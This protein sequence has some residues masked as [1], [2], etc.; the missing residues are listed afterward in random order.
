MRV[1]CLL[2]MG[3][4][5]AAAAASDVSAY[6]MSCHGVSRANPTLRSKSRTRICLALR[7]CWAKVAGRRRCLVGRDAH[8]PPPTSIATCWSERPCFP[9]HGAD[10]VPVTKPVWWLDAIRSPYCL[11]VLKGPVLVFGAWIVCC[12]EP[13]C[14]CVCSRFEGGQG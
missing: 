6:H 5:G 7:R 4:G 2:I 14:K 3:L 10:H 8:P 11:P 9:H 12:V 1:A 13:L